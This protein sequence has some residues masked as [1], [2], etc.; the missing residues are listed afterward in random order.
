[1][2]GKDVGVGLIACGRDDDFDH[3]HNVTFCSAICGRLWERVR[4]Q[5]GVNG[6]RRTIKMIQGWDAAERA[7]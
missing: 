2:R 5:P 7:A 1:V 4:V 3:A 6:I